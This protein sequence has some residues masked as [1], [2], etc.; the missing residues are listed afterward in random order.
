MPPQAAQIWGV[1]K[2]KA[3][4]PVLR[5]PKG[6]ESENLPW[7]TSMGCPLDRIYSTFL[8]RA[9]AE[10]VEGK[11]DRSDDAPLI[12]TPDSS[13]GMVERIHHHPASRAACHE[14][15]AWEGFTEGL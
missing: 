8:A 7:A 15:G 6:R 2:G 5:L 13:E 1:R 4:A 14:V 3:P 10:L 12:E 11:G 9:R